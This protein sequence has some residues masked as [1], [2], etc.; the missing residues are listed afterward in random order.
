MFLAI[1]GVVALG[2]APTLTG[3]LVERRPRRTHV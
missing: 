3:Y 1:F 2:V